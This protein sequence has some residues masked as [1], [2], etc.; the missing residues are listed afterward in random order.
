MVDKKGWWNLAISVT[1]VS[2][3]N[4]VFTFTLLLLLLDIT[5][6]SCFPS[7]QLHYCT[8]KCVT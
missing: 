2:F 5:K 8:M 1:E 3:G 4:G 7:I 6:H